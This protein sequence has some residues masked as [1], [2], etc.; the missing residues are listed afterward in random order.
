[1]RYRSKPSEID[2]IQ[3]TGDNAVEVQQFCGPTSNGLSWKFFVDFRSRYVP[4]RHPELLPRE[5]KLLAGKDGAQEWVPVP[6]GHWLVHLPG[7]T[8]DVWP[9]EDAYFQAKYEPVDAE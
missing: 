1:M 4:G 2:A 9:V 7:D 8:T 3:W 5:G 6:V